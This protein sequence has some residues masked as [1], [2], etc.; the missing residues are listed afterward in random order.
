MAEGNTGVIETQEDTAPDNG[1]WW[2]QS[3]VHRGMVIRDV[4]SLSDV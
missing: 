2:L 1:R 4:T 3:Y